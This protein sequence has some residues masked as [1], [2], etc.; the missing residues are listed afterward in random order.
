MATKPLEGLLSLPQ[1]A[2]QLGLPESSLRRWA[3]LGELRIAA[4]TPGGWRYFDPID[5]EKFARKLREDIR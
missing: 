1:A 3:D 4:E 5:L 2:K